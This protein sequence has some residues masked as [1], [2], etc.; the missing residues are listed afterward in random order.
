MNH[1][2]AVKRV[3][4]LVKEGHIGKALSA[5]NAAIEAAEKEQQQKE[6]HGAA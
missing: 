4:Q 2:E 6:D 1:I 5:I 3:A